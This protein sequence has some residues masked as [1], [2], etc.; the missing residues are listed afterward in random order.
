MKI[1]L[2][3]DDFGR[4]PIISKNI[5]DCIDQGGISQVSVM[6]GFVDEGIHKKL[7]KK[8]INTRLH[9]NLTENKFLN[10]KNNKDFTFIELLFLAKKDRKIIFNEIIK[11]IS[12]YSKIYKTKKIKLDGHQHVHM[13]PWIYKYIYNLK[14]YKISEIRYSDEK[15]IYFNSRILFKLKFYR[16]LLAWLLIKLLSLKNKRRYNYKFYGLIF[17]DIFNENLLKNL[18]NKSSKDSEILLHPGFTNNKEKRL[19]NSYFFKYYS[20]KQRQLEKKILLKL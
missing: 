20:S 4:S 12:E 9:L 3:A 13:I 17:S 10:K 15:F 8:K 7:I 19:F 16:N 6:M 2:H 14:L 1:I 5:I 18:I 11:Q